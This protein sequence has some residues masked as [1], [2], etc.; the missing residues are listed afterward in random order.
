VRGSL[1]A[2]KAEAERR[3]AAR[4]GLGPRRSGLGDAADE[5]LRELESE[6]DGTKRAGGGLRARMLS[7][8]SN[9]VS[10]AVPAARK[11]RALEIRHC[12]SEVAEVEVLDRVGAR[13]AVRAHVEM[14]ASPVVV[15]VARS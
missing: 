2:V 8:R 10:S 15:L 5:T 11:Q 13:V 9:E 4:R 3:A 12:R 1:P 14:P 6:L 7:G